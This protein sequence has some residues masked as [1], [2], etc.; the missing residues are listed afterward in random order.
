MLVS[1]RAFARLLGPLLL[2]VLVLA[3]V[4]QHAVAA[5]ILTI[6]AA[7]PVVGVGET[8]DVTVAVSGL[9]HHAAPSLGAFEVTIDFDP[10]VL[11][12]MTVLYGDPVLGNQLNLAGYGSPQFTTPGPASVSFTEISLDSIANLNALQPGAFTLLTAQ[13]MAIGTGA[14]NLS[15]SSFR[16]GDAFGD[17]TAASTTAAVLRVDPLSTPEPSALLL[18]ATGL[19]GAFAL[20]RKR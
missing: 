2:S 16:L 5:P 19:A 10:S 9:G 8:I 13:F 17:R 12:F 15:L 20:R 6:G 14:T 18:I 7:S 4:P 3:A 1:G 11:S